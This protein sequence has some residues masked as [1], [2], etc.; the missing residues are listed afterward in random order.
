MDRRR[1]PCF[2]DARQRGAVVSVTA[3]PH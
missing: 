1:R 3:R 2:D